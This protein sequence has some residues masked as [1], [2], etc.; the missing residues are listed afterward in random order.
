[1]RSERKILTVGEY[2]AKHLP[3]A[4]PAPTTLYDLAVARM[5]LLFPGSK[6]VREL[7]AK[8]KPSRPAK[9]SERACPFL[10]FKN[11]LCRG[12]AAD[13]LAEYSV[14]PSMLGTKMIPQPRSPQPREY[15]RA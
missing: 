11:G 10:P 13:R 5:R 7:D 4:V 9:C 12:H 3:H 14:S 15:V 2:V 8:L 1:M 6:L